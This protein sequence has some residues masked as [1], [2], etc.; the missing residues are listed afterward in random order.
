MTEPGNSPQGGVSAF[1]VYLA[2]FALSGFAGLIYESIWSHYFRLFLGHAAYAQV[3]VLCIFMGGMALGSAIAG[4]YSVRLKNLLLAYAVV[5]GLVALFGLTFHA[6]FTG[7]TGHVNEILIPGLAS[8][9]QVHVLKWTVA[10]LL[11]LPQ[12]VLLGMTF[13]LMSGGL[14]R[15]FPGRTGSRIALLYFCNSIGGAVGVLANGFWFVPRIGL[16]G[17]VFTAGL[18]NALLAL[19]VW[20]LARR[21][22][23]PPLQAPEDAGR[24]P[25]V[26]PRGSLVAGLLVVAAVTG[27][28]S[29]MYEIGW[30]R[31][32]SLVLGSSTHAFELMLS[33]FILGLALGGYWIHKRIDGQT[34]LFRTLG[35]IQLLMGLCALGSMLVYDQ[36]FNWMAF[37]LS[38]LERNDAGYALFNLFSHGI[39]LVIM[40]P[41]TVFAG[42]TLPLLTRMLLGSGFGERAIGA[43]YAA[44]TAGA[45]LG[46]VV[47][48]HL[49]IATLGLKYVVGIGAALDLVLGI[50]LLA[51]R[52][53][54]VSLPTWRR[55][56]TVVVL[57]LAGV[58]FMYQLD[59]VKMASGVYRYGTINPTREV[60][61]HRDGKTA[62]VDFSRLEEADTLSTNGKPDA[63]LRRDGKVSPDLMT[64]VLL[65]AV[66]LS[67][68][69][70][71]KRAAV[72]GMGSGLTSAALLADPGLDWVDTI[73][74]EPAMIEAARNFG[75]I[76]APTFDD[77]RSRLHI[78]DAKTFFLHSG[79][80]Y[81]LVVSE[82]SNP[83]VSGIASL[84]TAEFYQL[85]ARYL[86]DDGLLVQWLHLYEFDMS[87]LVSVMRAM[88]SAFPHYEIYFTNDFD[89][90]IVASRNGRVPPADARVFA[91]PGMRERLESIGMRDLSDLGE[92][93]VG[94][95]DLLG[96]LF[97]SYPVP[98]NSDYFPYVDTRSVRARYI[99]RGVRELPEIKYAA[100]PVL[101]LLD[102]VPRTGNVEEEPAE[103]YSIDRRIDTARNLA[104]YFRARQGSGDLAAVTLTPDDRGAA[105]ILAG[106]ASGCD[107]AELETV[108]MPSVHRIAKMVLPFLEYDESR[109]IWE[110]LLRHPCRD[111]LPAGGVEW[112]ELYDAVASRDFERML[113]MG[114][115]LLPPGPIPATSL[116]ARAL[117]AMLVGALAQNELD[118]ARDTWERYAGR[119]DPPVSLRLLHAQMF[120]R[121]AYDPRRRQAATVEPVAPGG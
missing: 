83:W 62:S 52:W 22:Q 96:P 78:E 109:A 73:E 115:E 5:E 79:I 38:A 102:G 65:G 85:V 72:V 10:G 23:D 69:P 37:A 45:I 19:I 74:I 63:G 43:V 7:I 75:P 100:I 116:S 42:M 4:R 88:S 9:V 53:G 31:M 98:A 58:G 6:L 29:F 94:S 68:H 3:L 17:A 114:W 70:D 12:S 50:V 84:Y 46:V 64:T 117:S 16:P 93:L 55:A 103:F 120:V 25:G 90:L 30:I 81:D 11:I 59:P 8:P 56:I 110:T 121:G 111:R 99:N 66:P 76:V 106:N 35:V 2:I 95:S 87:L 39:C 28:A 71:P 26:A 97:D 108:W 24:Q 112:L 101:R 119:L 1:R 47:A 57:V 20:M 107:P 13:P 32:L 105:S 80:R 41:A 77:P 61:F 15:A 33:A 36:T 21:R 92:R 49:V 86:A 54:G 18:L 82:P 27:M 118:L 89:I 113:G 104:G 67:M 14:L 60:V 40:L 91:I 48:V 34:N 44:N 51:P